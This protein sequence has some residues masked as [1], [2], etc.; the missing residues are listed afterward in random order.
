MWL[1]V[2]VNWCVFIYTMGDYMYYMYVII[3]GSRL[4][5]S[6]HVYNRG[7]SLATKSSATHVKD[8]R[9]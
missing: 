5:I 4:Q 1:K 2:I 3:V 8:I 7:C 6:A 9:G